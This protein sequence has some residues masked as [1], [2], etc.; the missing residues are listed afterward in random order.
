MAGSCV[1]AAA[2]R[3][4]SEPIVQQELEDRNAAAAASQTLQER[5]LT[6][7]RREMEIAIQGLVLSHNQS[8]RNG[9][10]TQ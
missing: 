4:L 1:K 10:I 7:L 8:V 2:K 6:V 9:S 3:R 5:C